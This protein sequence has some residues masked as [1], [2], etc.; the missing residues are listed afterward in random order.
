MKTAALAIGILALGGSFASAG[1]YV[2][3]GVGDG[4]GTS[5][6]GSY[7][8]TDRTGKILLGYS[9]GHIAVEGGAQRGSVEDS[10]LNGFDVTQFSIALKYNLPLSDGFEAF[11]RGGL[12]QTSLGSQTGSTAD[13][14][15]SGLLLGAG[16][17]YKLD[18]IATSASIFLDYNFARSSVTAGNGAAPQTFDTHGF[19]LGATIGF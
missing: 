13:L 10:N 16:I 8:S 7:K 18:L 19:L 12:Q 5:G 6:D 14:S 9:F 4:L 11:G 17:E 2:G 1:T 15:G 3:L